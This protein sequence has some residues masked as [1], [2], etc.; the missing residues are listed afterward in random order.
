VT[1]FNRATPAV[2]DDT[3]LPFT[4]PVAGRKCGTGAFD[5]GHITSDAGAMLIARTERHDDWTGCD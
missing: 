4:P 1:L 5:G 3:P 2:H